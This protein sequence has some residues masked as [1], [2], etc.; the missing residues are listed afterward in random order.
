MGYVRTAGMST[1]ARRARRRAALVIVALVAALALVLVVSMAYMQGLFGLG[2]GSEEDA[3]AT[4]AA[5]V[6]TLPAED[7]VVNVFNATSRS[8]LAGR[9]GD[10]LTARGFT[11]D[12]VGNS[13]A[14]IEGAGQIIHGPSGTGGAELLAEAIGQDLELVQDEREDATVDVVLG[15]AWEELPTGQEAQDAEE[16][17]DGA[18]AEDGD[19]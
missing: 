16:S 4:T 5:P 14:A 12:G 10:G 11:V 1:A 17:G 15:D 18:G 2:G 7:V 3:S 8:G 13:D 9:A 6:P 19:E